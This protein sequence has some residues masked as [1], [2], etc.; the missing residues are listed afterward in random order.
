MDPDNKSMNYDN[1]ISK[2]AS[3]SAMSVSKPGVMS[4]AVGAAVAPASKSVTNSDVAPRGRPRGMVEFTVPE[5]T[6][7]SSSGPKQV[8]DDSDVPV[9]SATNPPDVGTNSGMSSSIT[10][11]LNSVSGAGAVPTPAGN[12]V[13]PFTSSYSAW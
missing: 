7:V 8:A 1:D 3:G 2:P 9:A 12:V 13:E 11:A 6:L 5:P 4:A 10:N